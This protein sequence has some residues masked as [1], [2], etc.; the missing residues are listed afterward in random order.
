MVMF[1]D[2][3]VGAIFNALQPEPFPKLY[4]KL[5]ENNQAVALISMTLDQFD[6]EHKCS[7]PA[8]ELTGEFA[9]E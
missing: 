1:K 6:P 5:R 9:N 7:V 8:A 3:P 2:L 4:L